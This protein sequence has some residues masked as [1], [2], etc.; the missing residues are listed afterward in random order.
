MTE[1]DTEQLRGPADIARGARALAQID[2]VLGA[3]IAAHEPLPERLRPDGFGALVYCIAGQQISVASARAAM[4]RLNEAGLLDDARVRKG[5]EEALRAAGM[6]RQKARY[7]HAIAAER[8]DY[9]ALRQMP[10]AAVL[11]RLCALPGV[12]PWTAQ[13]YAMFSLG[14]ADVFA[15]GDLALQEAVRRI[16]GLDAR[17]NV[18]ELAAFAQ[19][20]APWRA[21]AA[22]ALWAYYGQVKSREGVA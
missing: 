6:T 1:R 10:D 22:R 18:P 8:V 21:V 13:I 14:R 16:Y 7:I 17:P 3:V 12:G 20:W 2:P 4:S 5:G 15:P 9:A 19:R 11:E